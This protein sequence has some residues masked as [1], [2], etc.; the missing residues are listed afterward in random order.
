MF[1]DIDEANTLI[2]DILEDGC[3]NDCIKMG[4]RWSIIYKFCGMTILLV[5][6]NQGLMMVGT[7]FHFFRA[8]SNCCGSILC[9]INFAA[10]IT[11]AVF[12]FNTIGQLAA[13]GNNP[14]KY[15]SD[16]SF[17][18][19]DAGVIITAPLNDDRNYSDDATFIVWLWVLQMLFCCF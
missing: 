7:R 2:E 17:S 1:T 5:A 13:L 10:I 19:N 6:I 14:T 18:F 12:R 11:T 4:C 9:C 16:K 3:D 8:I 15:D